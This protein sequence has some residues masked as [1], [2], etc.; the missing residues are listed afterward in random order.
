MSSV[1]ASPP[2]R[3][4]KLTSDARLVR[5]CL[6][7]SEAAWN[8]LIEKYKKLIY[9]IP[10]KYG[11]SR[12][13]AADIFQAVCLDLLNDL[14]RLREPQA[15][16]KWLIQVSSH[17]CYQWKRQMARSPQPGG[18]AD[19]LPEPPVAPVAEG[20]LREAENEQILREAIAALPERCQALVAMLFY[21]SP[22]R[23]YREIAGSLGIAVG[24]IGFIR[25]RCLERL[26]RQL[27]EMN[28]K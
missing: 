1:A 21:E 16:P 13:D 24:S 11:F 23:P 8:E 7:G 2:N 5:E 9:S 18:E 15:L 14:P 6:R 27:D 3:A 17:K 10:V 25:Q 26:R 19:Q 28:F 22:S 12:E 4:S 20:I